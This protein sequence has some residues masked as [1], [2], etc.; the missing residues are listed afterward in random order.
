[1]HKIILAGYG[2]Q[3]M[4]LCGQ[5]LANA[6]MIDGFHVTWFPT[7]G[8][9]MRGGAAACSVVI[10]GKPIGSPAIKSAGLIA[11]MSQPAFDK[12]HS[13]VEAGGYMMYNS[14]LVTPQDKRT[15]IMYVDA[16]YSRLS[17]ELGNL[18]VANMLVLGGINEI[19]SCVSATALNQVI[20]N[21]FGEKDKA[22][23]ELNENAIEVG[24]KTVK[25]HPLFQPQ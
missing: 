25:G 13:H 14:E 1:M 22:L 10:S 24:I 4:L 18:K 21:V 6:A 15:D 20:R 17:A 19:L 16:E 3:G 11:V 12:Y 8:P 2:G 9:E 7:Y 23:A 5:I